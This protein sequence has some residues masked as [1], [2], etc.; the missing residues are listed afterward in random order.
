[1]DEIKK[2]LQNASRSGQNGWIRIHIEGEPY[3]RG[4]Q[5]GY[6]L[7]PEIAAVINTLRHVTYFNTG[8]EFRFFAEAAARMF[9]PQIDPEY[10]EEIR[11]I[12]DGAAAGG[13]EVDLPALLAWNGYI[14]LVSYWWPSAV[15]KSPDYTLNDKEHCSA[16][17]ASGAATRDGGIIMAHNSWDNYILG[18]YL[19]IILDLVPTEGNRIFMQAG[20]GYIHSFTDFFVTGAGIVG[21]ET[22]I[23]GFKEY[24]EDGAPEFARVRQAMQYGQTIEGWIERMQEGNNGGYANSWL[25]GDIRS[26]EIARFEQGL[27]Y[28]SVTKT[29]DGYFTGCNAPEDARIRNLECD[30]TGYQDIRFTGARRVRWEQLMSANYGKIDL[31]TAAA[32]LADHYD[33]YLEEENNPCMR[34]IC[35]HSD[36]D[37]CQF[38]GTSGAL[39]YTPSGAF[40]GKVL[41]GKLAGEMS[42]WARFGRAC[43]EP[44]DAAAFLR[45]HPQWAWQKGYLQDRPAQPWTL[46]QAG[47]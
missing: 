41:S 17:I 26:N 42:F 25:L 21:T 27:S 29:K 16:F 35:G 13:V 34:T 33:V 12:A 46:F 44:F 37:P 18:Q 2:R 40:D 15:P 39:P 3:Q 20:P 14:E 10:L 9:T 22:T 32:M 24:R 4:F 1:M 6:L 30:Y 31:K 11:G 8:K 45:R 19:N 23:A 5:H 28:S 38:T 36:L 43:G 7:A 47:R